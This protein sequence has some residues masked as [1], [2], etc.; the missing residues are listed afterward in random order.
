MTNGV[1]AHLNKWQNGRFQIANLCSGCSA[2]LSNPKF[3]CDNKSCQSGVKSI[4]TALVS[5][6]EFNKLKFTKKYH[7]FNRLF[8]LKGRNGE[9]I[10]LRRVIN[11]AKRTQMVRRMAQK[12]IKKQLWYKLDFLS[13]ENLDD[14]LYNNN[15]KTRLMISHGVIFMHICNRCTIDINNGHQNCKRPKRCKG[16]LN[17]IETFLRGVFKDKID[18][19]D[20]N[21]D[22]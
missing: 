11:T 22:F 16:L 9:S 19:D 17:D 10:T 12:K 7:A 8:E 18:R 21:T 6:F 4:E 5:I 2:Y 3:A 20:F 15:I 13:D 1:S 14:Y